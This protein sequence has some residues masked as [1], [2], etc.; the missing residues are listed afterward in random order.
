MNQEP[1]ETTTSRQK[2]DPT[3]V[4]IKDLS[5]IYA[6]AGATEALK[7]VSIDVREGEFLVILGPSGAGKSTLMRCINRLVEPT[8]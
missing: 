4:S 5:K 1:T 3:M 7:N 6:G 2:R 8:S